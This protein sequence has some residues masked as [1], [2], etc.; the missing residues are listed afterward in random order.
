MS[1]SMAVEDILEAIKSILDEEDFLRIWEFNILVSVNLELIGPKHDHGVSDP[2]G[3][4]QGG[5]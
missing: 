5:I 2:S 1:R 3:T 4:V